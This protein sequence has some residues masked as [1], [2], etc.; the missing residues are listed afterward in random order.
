MV[1]FADPDGTTFETLYNSIMRFFAYFILLLIFL[2]FISC[3]KKSEESALSTVSPKEENLPKIIA[4][5]NSLTAGLGLAASESYPAVL[6]KMLRSKGYKYEVINA[7]VSG[8]TTAG[9][10]RRIDWSLEPGTQYLILELGANDILRGQPLDLMKQNLEKMIEKAQ[11]QG[12][13]VLLA[14]MEAPANAGPEYRKEAHEAFLDLAATYHITLIPFLLKGILGDDRYIQPDG[15]HP[16]AAGAKILAQNVLNALQ[17]L[18][19]KP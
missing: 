19:K 18:L 16:N 5:G 4:F 12:V 10:L 13:T 11:G 7:G 9:G 2:T 17:P 15:T 14:Q 1:R 6:E 8:D 3:N